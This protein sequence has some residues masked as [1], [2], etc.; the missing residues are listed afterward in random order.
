MTRTVFRDVAV[1]R[2]DGRVA[3]FIP[4]Q[5]KL[6]ELQLSASRM[7][8]YI[9]LIK[10][11]FSLLYVLTSLVIGFDKGALLMS[12]GILFLSIALFYFRARGRLRTSVNW[13]MADVAFVAIIGCSFFLGRFAFARLAPGSR[14]FPCCTGWS[15][16][17][18]SAW[19]ARAGWWRCWTAAR[20]WS[21]W[22]ADRSECPQRGLANAARWA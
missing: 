2:I 9:C 5:A 12:T 13:Y 20:S 6:D 3:W 7:L 4:N 14:W 10:A 19:S 8:V 18:P 15:T 22:F 16:Q 21:T 1:G 17:P 11:G